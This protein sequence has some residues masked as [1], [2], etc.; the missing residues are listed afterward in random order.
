[1]SGATWLVS[2]PRSGNTWAR[3]AMMAA[4]G[5]PDRADLEQLDGFARAVLDR[6]VIDHL[7][8]SDS[9]YLDDGETLALR[10]AFHVARFG[11]MS[12]SPIVKVHDKCL[13]VS[14]DG[15]LHPPAA[16]HAAIYLIRDP[17]DV[18]IS[19]AAFM[20]RPIDWAIAFL[21][22]PQAQVGQLRHR[23]ST[24]VPEYLGSWSDH[25]ASWVDEAP[26]PVTVVRYEDMLREPAL[27]LGDMLNA[28]G[29][30]VAPATLERAVAASRF[31]RLAALEREAGFRDRPVSAERFFRSGRSQAWRAVLSPE[32]AD[33]IAQAHGPMMR[34]F[35]YLVDDNETAFHELAEEF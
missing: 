20:A 22:D 10:A 19:W 30:R 16:T 17:R 28:A 32:Q 7:M 11:G 34:R 5:D 33:A 1:M 31:D 35:G 23:T 29:Y 3:F 15:C 27:C 2:Y 13:R 18:A 14:N 6:G 4:L 26:Y 8:E 12:P 9:G 21:S 24:T 25:V